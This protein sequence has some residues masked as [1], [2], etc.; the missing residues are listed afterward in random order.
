MLVELSRVKIG[1]I[2]R[3]A[4]LLGLSILLYGCTSYTANIKDGSFDVNLPKPF[5]GPGIYTTS[6]KLY[7]RGT[8]SYTLE[9]KESL[10]LKD[11]EKRDSESKS[12]DDRDIKYT[13]PG[14]PF[15]G[16]I[17]VFYKKFSCEWGGRLVLEPYPSGI[18]FVGMNGL[19]GEFGLGLRLGYSKDDVRYFGQY[20]YVPCTIDGCMDEKEGDFQEE[21]SSNNVSYGLY[22]YSSFFVTKTLFLNFST[23]FYQPWLFKNT[24]YLEDVPSSNHD[25]DIDFSLPFFLLQYAGASFIILEHV[26]FSAGETVFYTPYSD[27]LHWQT[28]FSMSYLF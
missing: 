24:I 20:V 16:S 26:Q 6:D 7:V 5:W 13:I 14:K 19:S 9:D 12:K 21:H 22:A 18:I 23:G 8:I 3:V 4:I 27:K 10:P 2:W 11:I 28:T 25:Y 1:S 15:S 17:D